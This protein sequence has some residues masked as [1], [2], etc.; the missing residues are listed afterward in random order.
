MENDKNINFYGFKP[1]IFDDSEILILGSFPSVKSR[2]NN[3]YYANPRNRFWPMLAK[4]FNEP[5]PIS[6][7]DKI[8]I[9][10]KHK[11]AIWDVA[12]QSDLSGSSDTNLKNSNLKFSDIDTLLKTHPS[13]KKILCNGSLAYNLFINNFSTDIY[14]AKMLST[15]PANVRFQIDDWAKELTN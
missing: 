14:V 3:F 13:I 10:Q 1:I 6:I 12:S 7:E 9:C 15:S 4:I 2:E 8:N 5:A 11:I